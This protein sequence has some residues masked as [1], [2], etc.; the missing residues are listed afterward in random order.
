MHLLYGNTQVLQ[1]ECLRFSVSQDG[2]LG[3]G[4]RHPGIQF[5]SHCQGVFKNT[6]DYLTPATPY[7]YYALKHNKQIYY[8]N[9]GT[10]TK[11][12]KVFQGVHRFSSLK[13]AN[14]I[15]TTSYT[16]DGKFKIKHHYTL[17]DKQIK[18]K[19]SITNLTPKT[20]HTIYFARGL[21]PDIDVDEYGSTDTIN[22]RGYNNANPQDFVYSKGAKSGAPIGLYSH[23]E[24]LHNTSFYTF[25][26]Q[27][28]KSMNAQQLFL[29]VEKGKEIDDSIIAIAFKIDELAP[30]AT[31]VME[32]KYVFSSDIKKTI[33]MRLNAN[34][35]IFPL[36]HT[37][38]QIYERIKSFSS[39]EVRSNG[40][41]AI[42]FPLRVDGV[43]E[44]VEIKI[45]NKTF[46]VTNKDATITLDCNRLYTIEILRNS[47]FKKTQ[48]FEIH[49]KASEVEGNRAEWFGS[50]EFSLKFQPKLP[51]ELT[52]NLLG[53]ERSYPIPYAKSSRYEAIDA[54]PS[55]TLPS[56][57]IASA[58]FEMSIENIPTG[59]MFEIEGKSFTK[60]RNKHVLAF[61]TNQTIA[62]KVL[63]NQ[64]FGDKNPFEVAFDFGELE[65]NGAQWQSKPSFSLRFK[66]IQDKG[67]IITPKEAMIIPYKWIKAYEKVAQSRMILNRTDSKEPT[68][69]NIQLTLSNI[70]QGIEVEIVGHRLNSKNN[71]IPSLDLQSD[72]SYPIVIFR[73]GT[74]KQK[75]AFAIG[76]EAKSNSH[77]LQLTQKSFD[78]KFQPKS[79]E[80]SL[81]P[82]T[83]TLNVSLANPDHNISFALFEESRKI[84]G[85]ELKEIKLTTSL[86]LNY[87]ITPN[88]EGF[89]F[90]L[91]GMQKQGCLPPKLKAGA[92][93]VEFTI[94]TPYPNEKPSAT[95]TMNVEDIP[96]WEKW[97]CVIIRTLI[98]ILFLLWLYGVVSNK[99]FA[100]SNHIKI[101]REGRKPS[102][103]YFAQKVSFLSKLIPFRDQR[104]SIE[105]V[106]FVAASRKGG[107]LIP[108][109][110]QTKKLNIDG[111]E[112]EE[113][114]GKR[115]I[116][117]IG[118]MGIIKRKKTMR[119]YV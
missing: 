99:K 20:L 102:H 83:A 43:P 96:F 80:L 66:P 24:V 81:K 46:N 64:A 42:T 63:R 108:K 107:A 49:F 93:R 114:A 116:R 59:V 19:T 28:A 79:R 11:R 90:E 98:I 70:P 84:L 7:E 23:S 10:T 62:I 112:L 44:G 37:K 53:E 117:L 30:N 69:N 109:R 15:D 4:K 17:E 60:E 73:N 29:G 113:S 13:T 40:I 47:D 111:E 88:K 41:N 104:V 77:T 36:P 58:A 52:V 95:I 39:F 57:E 101:E 55:F 31:K 85:E 103:I 72:R 32:Y 71:T 51:K 68:N 67:S 35:K 50:D 1:N 76:F 115:D 45:N 56:K 34:E 65:G 91:K 16:Q 86:M 2:T 119:F 14:S 118:G 100:K 106:T 78:L 21:D 61:K 18:I 25:S 87:T 75:E 94:T 105:G 5:D 110:S 22:I 8:A 92:N 48:P 26:D 89:R 3:D 12:F 33:T 6:R 74:F 38:S 9:N 54:K 27:E 97:G 82:S